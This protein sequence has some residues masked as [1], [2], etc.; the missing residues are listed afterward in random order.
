MAV[1]SVFALFFQKMRA[2]LPDEALSDYEIWL[3]AAGFRRMDARGAMTSDCE[4]CGEYYVQKGAKTIVFHHEKLAPP[5]GVAGANYS[6]Q[7]IYQSD[8]HPFL[9]LCSAI[10]RENMPHK[11]AYAWT[12]SRSATTG[13]NFYLAKY[14][15][16]IEQAANT[17]HAWCPTDDHGTSLIGSGPQPGVPPFAQQGISFVSSMRLESTWRKYKNNQLTAEE[18]AAEFAEGLEEGVDEERIV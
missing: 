15:I 8:E 10:H 13:G 18:A 17:F 7:V 2:V 1:S 14:G 11:F 4:G 3:D 6:R 9:V 12:T 5:A 16:K